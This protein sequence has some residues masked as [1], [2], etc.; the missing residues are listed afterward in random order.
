LIGTYTGATK[1]ATVTPDWTTNPDATS[2]YQVL[3]MARVDVAGWLG[4]LVT[5]DG[6]WAQLQS[7][8]TAI[9]AD[10]AD[11]QPKLGTPAADVSA[12]IAAV[13]A[14]TALIVADTNELQT[15]DVPGRYWRVADRLG[16]RW[17]PRPDP[18]HPGP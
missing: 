10:T 9:L 17:S 7:D 13:K 8:A 3:P 6:D 16:E 2:V 18:G 11:M 12:D 1:V 14:E 5:G 15:D 4:N